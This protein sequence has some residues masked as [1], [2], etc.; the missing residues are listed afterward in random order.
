MFSFAQTSKIKLDSWR[1]VF[2]TNESSEDHAIATKQWIVFAAATVG[3][4]LF[5]AYFSSL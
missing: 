3:A 1:D 5:A 4:A 2:F